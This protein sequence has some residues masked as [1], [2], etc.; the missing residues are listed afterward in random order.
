VSLPAADLEEEWQQSA[1]LATHLLPAATA[2]GLPRLARL[3]E[4]RLCRSIDADN[5]AD[6]LV[7]AELHQAPVSTACLVVD[8]GCSPYR[9]RNIYSRA[10]AHKQGQ[11]LTLRCRLMHSAHSMCPDVPSYCVLSVLTLAPVCFC[12]ISSACRCRWL[13]R[14]STMSGRQMATRR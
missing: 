8:Q 5:A 9:Y 11:S 10:A 13:R 1:S 14:T 7:L 6:M 12:R 2:Y 3:S 4:Q